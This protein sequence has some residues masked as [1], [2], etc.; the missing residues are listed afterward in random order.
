M[1]RAGLTI[2]KSKSKLIPTHKGTYLGF[3]INTQKMGFIAPA[4]KIC[5]LK[6]VLRQLTFKK[7]ATAKELARVAGRIISLAPAMGNLTNLFTRQMY[8]F[9]ETREAWYQERII[10][11]NVIE[12]LKFWL[13]N[14]DDKN[15]HGIKNN[16]TI[17]KVIY[18][19]ASDKGYG[20][21][22]VQRLGKTI[23][24][25][26]FSRQE[27]HTSSTYRE[28]AAVNYM[29]R[30]FKNILRDETIQWNSDNQNVCRI[31]QAGSTKPD[32]QSLALQI[33]HT[34]ISNNNK[35]YSVWIPR[36]E[37]TFTTFNENLGFVR[38]FASPMIRTQN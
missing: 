24:Q 32:F 8:R 5:A 12:E 15:G 2:N 17:T 25:G 9:I 26:K 21:Y 33:Y 28:L 22:I 38:L 34:C 18:S 1:T 11:D 7:H 23:A 3:I 27:K 31:I 36:E 4:E 6:K 10:P 37:N 35:I 16:P 30:S 29:L 20:G 14:L 13:H 19:D